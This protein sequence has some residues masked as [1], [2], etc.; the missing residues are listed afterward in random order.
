M[1]PRFLSLKAVSRSKHLTGSRSFIRSFLPF[2]H[3]TLFYIPSHSLCMFLH[4]CLFWWDSPRPAGPVSNTV[5]KNTEV[6]QRSTITANRVIL[7]V[8]VWQVSSPVQ[9]YLPSMI[10]TD[11]SE[12]IT[13]SLLSVLTLFTGRQGTYGAAASDIS[14]DI[15][16]GRCQGS[17][18]MGLCDGQQ[19][20]SGYAGPQCPRSNCGLC[21]K[22]TNKGGYG[23]SEIGGVGKHIIV[24][25]IDSCPYTHACNFCK[26]NIPAD[27]RCQSHDKNQLDIDVS[28]YKALTD[29]DFGVCCS[30]PL[31][32]RYNEC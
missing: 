1:F 3:V 14:P 32:R 23:N 27:Q 16:G 31:R 8:V 13:S 15:T 21:Y 6:L 9:H 7:S 2:R 10:A 28:A 22:V 19:A 29:Q 30:Y 26:T 12:R 20:K 24:E 18:D 5:N 17:I 4:S 25:I 11:G